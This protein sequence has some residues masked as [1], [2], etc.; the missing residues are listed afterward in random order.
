MTD[1]QSNTTYGILPEVSTGVVGTYLYHRN[2]LGL[3]IWNRVSA[4]IKQRPDKNDLWQVLV[5][6]SIGAVRVEDELVVENQ[7]TN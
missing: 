2:A 5:K 4:S 6:T 3:G 1:A 7:V